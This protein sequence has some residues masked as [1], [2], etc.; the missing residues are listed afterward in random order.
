V[1]LTSVLGASAEM[2]GLI[3]GV[4]GATASISKLLSGWASDELGKRKV[5][6]VI[7]YGLA[8]VSKPLFALA[9]TSSLVLAARFSDRVGK[10]IREAPRV[11][12]PS[13]DHGARGRVIPIGD[14]DS[15]NRAALESC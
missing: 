2:V 9:T 15:P 14:P 3:G 8:T 1:F 5:F 7:A 6:T 12:S 4:G 11:R 10:G 13:L